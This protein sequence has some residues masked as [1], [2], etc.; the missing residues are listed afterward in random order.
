MIIS[1]IPKGGLAN[2]ML[3]YMC[4][5][6]LAW[7]IGGKVKVNCSL[8]EWNVHFDQSLHDE[9]MRDKERT[10]IFR[11]IDLIS[12]NDACS[13]IQA[14]ES[15]AIILDGFFQRMHL[16]DSP[17]RYRE[18][19]T[20]SETHHA[21]FESKELLIHIRAG[22]ILGGVSWYP[23]VPIA[24]YRSLVA[25]TGFKP[26]F[27][28][29]LDDSRYIREIREAFPS[30]R[31]IAA[32]DA[33]SDFN[34]L[35]SARHICISVSTF[36]WLAA[37]L[38]DAREIHYP[39]LGFLHPKCLRYGSR[40][41]GGVDLTP[42]HDVRYRFHLFP[43][44]QGT[45]EEDYLPFTRTIV[46]I[47]K[48]IPRSAVRRIQA[49]DLSPQ[50][51]DVDEMFDERWYLRTYIDAAWGIS[52]GRHLNAASHYK[53]LGRRLGYLPHRPLFLPHS[54]NVAQG[55]PATQ[56][57]LSIWSLGKTLEDDAARAVDGN[58]RKD[59]AFHTALEDNPWWMV[60]L[61]REYQIE[62]INVY[63][64]CS[65]SDVIRRRAVPFAIDLS[66]DGFSWRRVEQTP[67]EVDVLREPDAE[68]PIP[69][70]W[71]C[72]FSYSA[73]FVK[74]IVLK[75]DYF[76]LAEVEVYGTSVAPGTLDDYH[77]TDGNGSA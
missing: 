11:D 71:V 12:I 70:Q 53:E 5:R 66:T 75:K 69:F 3:S 4:A 43:V 19:F 63:N 62:C 48:E 67:A 10:L 61:Q 7:S 73:R 39:M 77:L 46:P 45:G 27:L 28:G 18:L 52:E 15:T 57:S 54:R 37:W 50:N 47:S 23:L 25:T 76:H 41:L 55:K 51:L 56:S 44:I 36:S 35:R 8:P 20:T 33:V 14:S 40:G 9:I 32:S 2:R 17:S 65:K 34:C 49:E 72:N 6:T 21:G 22:D 58:A 60:D 1:V 38:S 30:A 74:L 59:M 68:H 13:A 29:Q 26:V 24:F 42:T 16:F 31:M 64:R